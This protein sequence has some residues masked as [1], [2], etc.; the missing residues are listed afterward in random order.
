MPKDTRIRY[1]NPSQNLSDMLSAG[2][3][4]AALIHQ[5][6]ACYTAGAPQI[7]RMFPDYRSAEI[8]YYRRTGIHPI[9][10]CVVLR[11][12]WYLHS[13][14]ALQ[15]IYQALL[16]ARQKTLEALSDTKA[17]P[18]MIP[19]L[20]SFMEETRELFGSDFWPYGLKSNRQALE[21][22]VLYAYQQGLSSRILSIE[23]LF[24]ENVRDL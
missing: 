3:V 8:D 11:N 23:E 7:K 18:A 15:S 14:W 4:D 13:P 9:M 5:A 1:M 22:L 6:P 20:P 2:E 16:T 10:H 21:K 19:M 24:G 12:D 17:F